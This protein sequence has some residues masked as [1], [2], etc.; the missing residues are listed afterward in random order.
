MTQW[1]AGEMVHQVLGKGPG[2]GGD[3]QLLHEL[4]GFTE[5]RQPM[6]YTPA[7][8]WEDIQFIRIETLVDPSWV[9][10]RE[11]EIVEP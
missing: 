10:W 2:T 9:S 5:D 7:I 6:E 8:P 3:F 1:P 4:H 11:I